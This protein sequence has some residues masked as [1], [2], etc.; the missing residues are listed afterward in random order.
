MKFNKL[1]FSLISILLV[2]T[3][4]FFPTMSRA[5]C[6][7][8]DGPVIK[9]A[10]EALET[11]NVNLILI[12]V[13]QE[14]EVAIREAFAKVLAVRK[15]NAAAKD[16]AD[17]YFFET[18][19]RTHRAGEGAPYTGLKPAGQDF[20]PAIP[21]ADKAIANGTLEPLHKLIVEKVEHGLHEHFQ[22]AL[23]AKNYKSDDIG[24]GREFIEAY[25]LYVHYVERLYEAATTQVESHS[26]EKRAGSENHEGH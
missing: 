15:L 16:L 17:M 18:L 13:Q 23:H 6:D 11:N 9:A 1:H 22:R 26:S 10:R 19:V 14:D 8:M 20:G 7:T 24:A 5:H 4:Y 2:G 21:A 12:W 3:I 25:V